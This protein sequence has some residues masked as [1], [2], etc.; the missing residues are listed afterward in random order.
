MI[1]EIFVR[2]S[3]KEAY[4]IKMKEKRNLRELYQGFN[5]QSK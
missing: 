1:R 2:D 5:N 4:E 3:N